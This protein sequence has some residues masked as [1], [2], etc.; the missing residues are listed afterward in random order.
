MKKNQ[1]KTR[2]YV[3]VTAVWGDDADSTIKVSRR[4]WN[5]IQE[6]AE[7][8]TSAWAMYEGRR[9]PVA[10]RFS[11]REVSVAATGGRDF[12]GLECVCD[13]PIEEL[14]VE[15]PPAE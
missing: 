13:L 6:G 10:W 2:T 7:Y 1:T 4:R 3:E 11:D 5:Q 15:M 9:Y 14:M 8:E 12:D